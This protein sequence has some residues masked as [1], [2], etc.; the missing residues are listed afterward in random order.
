MRAL[1]P[2]P[3]PPPLPTPHLSPPHP[4]GTS[5]SPPPHLLPDNMDRPTN[6][7]KVVDEEVVLGAFTGKGQGEG[8]VRRVAEFDDME[9]CAAA[10]AHR[11]TREAITVPIFKV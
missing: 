10:Y 9:E 6:V 5:L 8:R 4:L 3:S 2:T 11:L 1:P 7:L